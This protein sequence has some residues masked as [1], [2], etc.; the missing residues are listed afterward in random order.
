MSMFV[1]AWTSM[2]LY[3]MNTANHAGTAA[4]RLT[5]KIGSLSVFMMADSGIRVGF[6]GYL[7]STVRTP[8]VFMAVSNLSVSLQHCNTYAEEEIN[9]CH[10]THRPRKSQVHENIL[11]R[12][13]SNNTS[14]GCPQQHNTH[15]QCSFIP[16]HGGAANTTRYSVVSL[17]SFQSTD[18]IHQWLTSVVQ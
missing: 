6:G 5:S 3:G 15:S 16:N 9:K 4:S 14:N 8:M 18:G 2:K 17:H 1:R 11:D 13:R 10:D 7:D 12:Y